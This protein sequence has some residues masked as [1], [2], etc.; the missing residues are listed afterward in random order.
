MSVRRLVHALLAGAAHASYL[1]PDYILPSSTPD[2]S[3]C[4]T[5]S[6]D[7]LSCG[8]ERLFDKRS[9]TMWWT[10]AADPWAEAHFE[11]P[12][13]KENYPNRI[14]VNMTSY[15]LSAH[16]LM[17]AVTP[18][19]PDTWRV[20]CLPP[21]DLSIELVERV[22]GLAVVDDDAPAACAPNATNCTAPNASNAT[23]SAR[24][25]RL[26]TAGVDE[27]ALDDGGQ[28]N[29]SVAVAGSVFE[30]T[31]VFT[32]QN[33]TVI[34]EASGQYGAVRSTQARRRHVSH[35]ETHHTHPPPPAAVPCRARPRA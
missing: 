16:T 10:E 19:L 5:G 28:L 26:N 27:D 25:R 1:S 23:A 7:G 22:L 24:R 3:G 20:E 17:P 21:P 15:A 4:D 18:H 9:D 11:L 31:R 13:L 29:A 14:A 2:A 32:Y 12:W 30:E 34:H 6:G 8:P 35:T 33:W